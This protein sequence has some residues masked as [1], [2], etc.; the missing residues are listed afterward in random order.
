MFQRSEIGKYVKV[1]DR[2]AVK[3]NKPF[4]TPDGNS[5]SLI[6][7]KRQGRKKRF[8]YQWLNSPLILKANT[9]TSKEEMSLK[10]IMDWIKSSK[11]MAK[12][13]PDSQAKFCNK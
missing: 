3:L 11:L 12:L 7:F 1:A 2:I 10:E 5:Y 8:T 13:P 4:V 6:E 9:I